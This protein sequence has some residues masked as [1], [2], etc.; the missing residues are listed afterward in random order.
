[1]ELDK[2][3]RLVEAWVKT[4]CELKLLK[5][6]EMEM[7]EKIC[8]LILKDKLS[9]SKKR[10]IGIYVLKVT[11][12]IN[13]NIDNELLNS[14]WKD[15]SQEERSAFKFKPSLV[16]KNYKKL[17]ENSKINTAITEKPGAPTLVLEGVKN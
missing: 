9:G 2:Q 3:E 14:I 15:L 5:I 4:S 16:P 12:R 6:K 17:S 13:K 11:E 1:M 8:K 7:R 10:T